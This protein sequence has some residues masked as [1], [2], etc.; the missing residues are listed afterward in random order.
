M[1]PSRLRYLCA[2]TLV[3]SVL[4]SGEKPINSLFSGVDRV[5]R[6]WTGDHS[7]N[8]RA[9]RR[10]TRSANT[11]I[12]SSILVGERIGFVS[13]PGRPRQTRLSLI[14]FRKQAAGISSNCIHAI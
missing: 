3:A 12:F 13:L 10:N 4:P 5:S 2:A 6:G 14:I 11:P 9:E 1:A 7:H 8:A